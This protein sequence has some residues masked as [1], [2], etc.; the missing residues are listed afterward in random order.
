MKKVAL[1]L[2]LLLLLLAATVAL[3]GDTHEWHLA[4]NETGIVYCSGGNLVVEH[5][6]DLTVIAHCYTEG[7]PKTD[8]YLPVGVSD[9]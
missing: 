3:A 9:D 8:L 5:I 2:L 1:P 6:D 4:N 7:Q